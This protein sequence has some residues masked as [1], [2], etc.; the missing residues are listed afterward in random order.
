MEVWQEGWEGMGNLVGFL[1]SEVKVG[2]GQIYGR[3]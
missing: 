3:L 2:S 1:A